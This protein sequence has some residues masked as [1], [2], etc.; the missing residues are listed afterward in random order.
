MKEIVNNLKLKSTPESI[1]AVEL[2]VEEITK[3]YCI[4]EDVFGNMIVSITEA[5]NNAII[6]GNKRE[7]SKFINISQFIEKTD[8]HQILSIKIKD[9]GDG[10]DYNNLADPTAPE[11]IEMIGGRGLF[12]IKHLA[13]YV[14]FNDSGN[15]IELQFKL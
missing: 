5:V 8:K 1:A 9:E 10:F 11:N 12:L 3:Q 14:I 15:S 2:F 13:D 4:E 7:K 6:H